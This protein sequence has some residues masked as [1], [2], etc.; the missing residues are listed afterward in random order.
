MAAS[1]EKCACDPLWITSAWE[2]MNP[3]HN[4]VSSF[5]RGGTELIGGQGGSDPN[6]TF[7]TQYRLC[8]WK[9]GRVEYK[10]D[11]GKQINVTED[12]V[13]ILGLTH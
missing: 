3:Y 13:S 10:F 11:G 8:H 6:F 4:F 12:L 1:G 5:V 9:N 2:F 7:A